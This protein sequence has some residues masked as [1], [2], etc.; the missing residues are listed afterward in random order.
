[1]DKLQSELI[2]LN[3][4]IKSVEAEKQSCIEEITVQK[5][6]IKFLHYQLQQLSNITK[7]H[8]QVK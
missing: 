7:V 3:R 2:K 4:E 8:I 5:Q 1:M 6:Q